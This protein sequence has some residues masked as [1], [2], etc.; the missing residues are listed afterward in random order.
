MYYTWS[1]FWLQC[2]DYICV[3]DFLRMRV[4]V[5]HTRIHGS[6][7]RHTRAKNRSL[8]L[9][10]LCFFA[11]LPT[12]MVWPVTDP[13]VKEGDPAPD[14]IRGGDGQIT[15]EQLGLENK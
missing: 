3:G 1:L 5:S 7:Q 8:L 6:T 9:F 11:L 2:E 14:E 4:L 12:T 10:F 13:A 15:A